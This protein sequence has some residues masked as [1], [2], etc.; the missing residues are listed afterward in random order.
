MRTKVTSP[1]EWVNPLV[2]V[3]KMSGDLRLCMGPKV[4]NKYIQHEYEYIPTRQELV[5]DMD[6]AAVFTKLDVSSAFYQIPICEKSSRLCTFNT[7][8]GWYRFLRLP[9]GIKS[10]TEVMHR[11]VTQLLEGL[12]GV[13]SIRDDIVIWGK[14]TAEQAPPECTRNSQEKQSQVQPGQV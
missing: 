1:T 11:T 7:P 10:A 2:I 6:G 12:E 9:F 8:F 3:E 4:L 14:N 13:K 5:S